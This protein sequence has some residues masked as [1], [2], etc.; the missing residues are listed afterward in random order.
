MISFFEY[1]SSIKNIRHFNIIIFCALVLLSASLKSQDTQLSLFQYHPLFVNPAFTGSFDSDWRFSAGYRNQQVVTSQSYKSAIAGIDGHFYI[2]N[3]KIG[4][5]L[6]VLNDQS[7]IGGLTFNKLYG[8]L[9][10][11]M[12]ISNN[13]I[14]VGLQGGFITGKVNDWNTWDNTAGAFTAPSGEDN[15][16]ENTSYID[17]NAG[18]SWKRKI[19]RLFPQVGISILHLNQPSISF[20]G[21]EEK[22]PIQFMLDSRMEI[23]LTE[24]LYITPLVFMKIQ[25]GINQSITGADIGYRLPK[26]SMV[27]SVFGGIHLHNGILESASSLL[28]H[29]GVRVRRI[30]IGFGYERNLG[31]Y[32][33]VTNTTGAFEIALV[34][35]SISTVL[36]TYSIPCERY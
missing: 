21:S 13:I 12:D 26:R 4:A 16:G 1:F 7:G 15:F 29:L 5:G 2:L 18:L 31:S 10:Y 3:Q 28:L 25:G 33:E 6:Y 19:N 27:K 36:N 34:Y 23:E 20:F 32:S 35:K 11:E 17:F 9:A 8:S 22:Q 24:K 30:D 14:G